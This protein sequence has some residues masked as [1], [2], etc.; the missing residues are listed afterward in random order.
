MSSIDDEEDA[1]RLLALELTES[2]GNTYGKGL[3]IFREI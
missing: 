2:L 3:K 1:A